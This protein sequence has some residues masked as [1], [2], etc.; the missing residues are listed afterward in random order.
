MMTDWVLPMINHELC[1]GCG[2]CVARCPTHALAM[3]DGRAWLVIPEACSYCA[4]CQNVCPEGAI[5]LP[6]EVVFADNL[7]PPG[8]V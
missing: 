2:E 1:A 5:A 3:R 7:F 6:Y 4:E 8:S